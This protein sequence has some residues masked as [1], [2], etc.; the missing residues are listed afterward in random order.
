MRQRTRG[1]GD[2][3]RGMQRK[4]LG[5]GAVVVGGIGRQ[6]GGAKTLLQLPQRR[7]SNQ[8]FWRLQAVTTR[9]R[10]RQVQWQ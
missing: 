5:G 7:L 9:V 2:P 10:C 4:G 8:L 1:D 6:T 3:L